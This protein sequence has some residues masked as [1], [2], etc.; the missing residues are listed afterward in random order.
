M[1]L[2]TVRVRRA[3][4]AT[5]RDHRVPYVAHLVEVTCNGVP[6]ALATVEE[7]SGRIATVEWHDPAFSPNQITKV[8]RESVKLMQ[9]TPREAVAA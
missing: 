4:T 3:R 5:C 8:A 1:F 7:T 9:A 2:T 6:I